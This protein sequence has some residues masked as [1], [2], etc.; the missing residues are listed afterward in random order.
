MMR[1]AQRGSRKLTA[2]GSWVHDGSLPPNW[3]ELVDVTGQRYYVDHTQKTTSWV[4]PRDLF[5]KPMVFEKC[6]NGGFAMGWE[7]AYDDE[8]TPYYIDHNSWNTTYDD[9]RVATTATND[10]SVIDIEALS[11]NF[12][13][14]AQ[15]VQSI[16]HQAYSRVDERPTT[17][18]HTHTHTHTHICSVSRVY[19]CAATP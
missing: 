4:D 5:I 16:M 3:E 15:Q 9:P 19:S 1:T 2:R 11:R 10:H 7:M 14:Q 13:Q 18:T 12:L 17:V 6:H 8:G